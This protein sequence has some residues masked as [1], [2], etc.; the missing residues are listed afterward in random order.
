MLI[1]EGPARRRRGDGL[2]WGQPDG[3]TCIPAGRIGRFDGH[4]E[5]SLSVDDV[6]VEAGDYS[7]VEDC[8]EP[9]LEPGSESITPRGIGGSILDLLKASREVG[10]EGEPPS[11]PSTQEAIQGM[12][13]MAGLQASSAARLTWGLAGVGS[14]VREAKQAKKRRK[15][16]HA[17][18]LP[19]EE[20]ESEED[21]L[22]PCFKDSDYGILH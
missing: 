13:S 22:E 18:G 8:E 21:D 1:D 15:G 6:K 9:S 12:L 11:S 2:G 5:L 17:P 20:E 7:G 16:V 3:T 4:R 14:V 19:T 10:S